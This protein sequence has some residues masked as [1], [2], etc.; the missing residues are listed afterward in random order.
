MSIEKTILY[1]NPSAPIVRFA[2]MDYFDDEEDMNDENFIST[3]ESTL[4]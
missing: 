3:T 4:G 2:S 1:D